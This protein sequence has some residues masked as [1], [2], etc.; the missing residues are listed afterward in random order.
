MT[1][2]C[3]GPAAQGWDEDER[4]KLHLFQPH[5]S[6]TV[7]IMEVVICAMM[8]AAVVVFFVYAFHYTPR[9]ELYST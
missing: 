7:I 8:I 3:L 4:N 5:K 6:K 9:L 2:V 1:L